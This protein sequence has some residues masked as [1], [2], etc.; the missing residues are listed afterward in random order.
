MA[1]AAKRSNNKT[2]H[3]L[4]ADAKH[5]GKHRYGV[6]VDDFLEPSSGD[7]L[8]SNDE[9]V[10]EPSPAPDPEAEI[11]YSFDAPRGASQG[12]EVLSSAVAQAVERFETRETQKLVDR[13]YDVVG[14][15]ADDE[16]GAGYAADDDFELL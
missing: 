1:R 11:T 9:S 13:E 3:G 14:K 12:A 6:T 10:R 15:E 2:H 16:D 8:S 4:A 5:M 7:C